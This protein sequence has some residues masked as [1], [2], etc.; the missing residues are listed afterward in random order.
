MRHLAEELASDWWMET[1]RKLAER[2]A[3]GDER[4]F[5]ALVARH[6]EPQLRYVARRYRAELAEDA[7]HEAFLSAH[8]AV[9][10]DAHTATPTP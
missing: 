2:A 7:V 6:R 8:R 5:T 1:D 9:H 3:V 4:A 10:T